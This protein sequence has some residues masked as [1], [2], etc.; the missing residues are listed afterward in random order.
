MEAINDDVLDNIH[1]FTEKLKKMKFELAVTKQENSVLPDGWYTWDNN[2]MQMP[3][4]LNECFLVSHGQKI[5]VYFPLLKSVAF[6]F[7]VVLSKSKLVKIV[8]LCH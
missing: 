3:S 1:K 8:Y 4:A 2:V 7:E 6:M 5:S